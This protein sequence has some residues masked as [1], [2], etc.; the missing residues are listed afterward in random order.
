MSFVPAAKQF[1]TPDEV[2]A[3]KNN[4]SWHVNSGM[5]GSF[6]VAYM[7]KNESDK[8]VFD[9]TNKDWPYSFEYTD[10]EVPSKVYKLVP[11]VNADW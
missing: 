10:E 4:D 5:G 6:S 7:G 2:K 11:D 8:H 9:S 3:L 1:I